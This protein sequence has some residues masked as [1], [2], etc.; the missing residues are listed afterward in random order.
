MSINAAAGHSGRAQLLPAT[1]AFVSAKPE[2]KQS[3]SVAPE[4]KQTVFVAAGSSQATEG[5]TAG[6]T[7]DVKL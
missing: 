7:F 2:Q 6:I 4:V 1:G 3:R 5:S